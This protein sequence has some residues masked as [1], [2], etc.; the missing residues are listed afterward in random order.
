ML[1]DLLVSNATRLAA[2]LGTWT[3]RSHHSTSYDGGFDFYDVSAHLV[4]HLMT[5]PMRGYGCQ[6]ENCSALDNEVCVMESGAPQCVRISDTEVNWGDLTAFFNFGTVIKTGDPFNARLQKSSGWVGPYQM[7]AAGDKD[8]TSLLFV[9]TPSTR[10]LQPDPSIP[11]NMSFFETADFD[12]YA[13]EAAVQHTIEQQAPWNDNPYAP[14]CD[15]GSVVPLLP[16]VQFFWAD[17][18]IQ[19]HFDYSIFLMPGWN[20]TEA[21]VLPQ[22]QQAMARDGLNATTSSITMDGP[23]CYH[24]DVNGSY[25][26]TLRLNSTEVA[27]RDATLIHGC[28]AGFPC[29]PDALVPEAPPSNTPSHY[30]DVDL[31]KVLLTVGLYAVS[32]ALLVALLS[33]YNLRHRHRRALERIQAI[34]EDEVIRVSGGR[35][36]VRSTTART[37]PFGDAS[38]SDPLREPLLPLEEETPRSC[39]QKAAPKDD[40]AYQE[41][42]DPPATERKTS[43]EQLFEPVNEDEKEAEE[44]NEADNPGNDNE[45]V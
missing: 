24:Q 21:H 9:S 43:A 6:L 34:H 22:V 2:L 38:D 45:V 25:A 44:D 31:H 42:T 17:D 19:A 23:F 32:L 12:S 8:S 41:P 28:L 10:L 14:G 26:L 16:H 20:S 11:M 29:T 15:H 30:N 13:G 18:A 3:A 36:R 39:C 7:L 5:D 33:N 27:H 35:S 37:T 1:T 4:V 40:A